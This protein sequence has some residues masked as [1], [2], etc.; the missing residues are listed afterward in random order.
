MVSCG[1]KKE[2]N[3]KTVPSSIPVV[4]RTEKP[5]AGPTETPLPTQIPKEAKKTIEECLRGLLA[6]TP[7]NLQA[8][9]F[10]ESSM[11]YNKFSDWK[12]AKGRYCCPKGYKIH[13]LLTS[14]DVMA[15]RQMPQLVLDEIST[16]ELYHL[17]Q[18]MKISGIWCS[19]AA[20]TYLDMVSR[21]YMSYNFMTEFI[22]RKNSEEVVHRFYLKYSKAERSMYTKNREVKNY[23]RGYKGTT[24][25]IVKQERFQMTEGLE[26]FYRYKMEKSTE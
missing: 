18:N 21:Y 20:D 25:D 17:I 1:K 11:K 5:S 24:S 8:E 7:E 13:Y 6:E 16:E 4:M 2:K 14:G 19:G 15:A 12:D 22:R 9:C 26:W 23:Q 3:S 10:K